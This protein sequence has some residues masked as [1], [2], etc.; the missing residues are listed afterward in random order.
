MLN[1]SCA[2]HVS[3]DETN[4][5][6][7]WGPKNKPKKKKGHKIQNNLY[8]ILIS[9]ILIFPK[10]VFWGFSKFGILSLDVGNNASLVLVFELFFFFFWKIPKS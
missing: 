5:W 2:W 4:I 9:S 8:S 6:N 7:K 3:K 1:Y 10:F